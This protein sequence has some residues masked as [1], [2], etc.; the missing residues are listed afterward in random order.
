MFDFVAATNMTLLWD[1]NGLKARDGSGPWQPSVNAT[2][3]LAY[4]NSKHGGKVDYAFSVGNEP[5]LWPI[6]ARATRL[7]LFF[8]PKLTGLRVAWLVRSLA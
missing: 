3:M 5:N 4:L 1:F 2:A 7:F 8:P 6:K